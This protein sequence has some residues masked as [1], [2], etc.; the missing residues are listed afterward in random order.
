STRPPTEVQLGVL[1]SS[2]VM[3]CVMEHLGLEDIFVAAQVC[4]NWATFAVTR[5]KQLILLHH[6]QV[7]RHGMLMECN[8]RKADSRSIGT[9]LI[10][11]Q[12]DEKVA[13]GLTG[14]H[15]SWETSHLLGW[16]FDE[17]YLYTIDAACR[18]RVL[19]YS[20]TTGQLLAMVNRE[21][22][23]PMGLALIEY[24]GEKVLYVSDMLN[25]RIAVFDADLKFLKDFGKKH[26]GSAY[27]LAHHADVLYVSDCARDA[28]LTFDLDG[29]HRETFANVR[30]PRGIAIARP[31]SCSACLLVAQQESVCVFL[32]T[33]I[34]IQVV[35][36]PLLERVVLEEEHKSARS[37]LW[38][39]SVADDLAYV[40]DQLNDTLH[41]FRIAMSTNLMINS[42]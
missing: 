8:L 37:S 1:Q 39:I 20:R 7:V 36:P 31:D 9:S 23:Y 15:F 24:Q 10:V 3:L 35:Q 27:G 18:S 19:K 30:N 38:G 2:D 26:I 16:A 21:L 17:S 25:R 12:N 22:R 6:E 41:V 40:A 5:R 14:E 4:E 29:Q 28:V 13:L 11:P 34:L 42:G 33:G 32:L